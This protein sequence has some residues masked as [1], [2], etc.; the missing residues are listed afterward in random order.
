MRVLMSAAFLTILIVSACGV[1]GGGPAAKPAADA[2]TRSTG[3]Q[4]AATSAPARPS[5][6][7]KPAAPAA[8]AAPAT[9]A[10]SAAEARPA[11]PAPGT[12]GTA[13]VAAAPALPGAVAQQPARPVP[14]PPPGQPA[15]A[16]TPAQPAQPAAVQA[17]Q[18]GRLVIYVT[19]LSLLVI[20]PTQAADAI[21]DVAT[22]AGGYIAGVE[23]KDDNGTAVTIVRSKVPPERYDQTMRQLRGLAVEVTSEKATTQDVTEEFNDVQTQLA[24]LE[25]SYKQLLELMGK[26]QNVDE[27][28]KI[29][30]KLS[31]TKVQIDRLKGRQT[32]LE[33]SSELAT[34]TVNLRPADD[35]LARTYSCQRVSYAGPRASERSSHSRC[36]GPAPPRKRPPC[37]ISLAT[38]CSRSTASTPASAR[39]NGSP[40]RQDHPADPPPDDA[41]TTPPRPARMSSATTCA[42]GASSAPPR[43]TATA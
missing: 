38:S 3:A 19:E 24:A 6:A 21:G 32:F 1:S 10:R 30:E 26:A 22:Q 12:A 29:Q 36:S 5:D 15:P 8:T 35:I 42:C 23:N 41:S 40:D 17:A 39:S 16:P 37:A 7:A 13:A 25:A 34:I 11:P 20:N 18:V 14:P 9:A 31:Q 43:P 4:V 28:L 33:R 2:E 27:I